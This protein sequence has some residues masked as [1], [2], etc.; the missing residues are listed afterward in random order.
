MTEKKSLESSES[1]KKY[2]KYFL[3]FISLFSLLLL[4]SKH[5]EISESIRYALRFCV[6]SIIP[7]IFPF[8]IFADFLASLCYNGKL[9]HLV[10]YI[11]GVNLNCFPAIICGL[12]CGF[13]SGVK[14]AV[15]LYDEGL[16]SKK[17]LE[18]LIGIIN[19]PSFAFS[20][21][22]VGLGMLGSFYDGFVLYS[23][24]VISS[25]FL[26]QFFRCKQRKTMNTADFH[27]QNFDLSNSIKDAG[28]SS[29]VVTSYIVFFSIVIKL[30][31]IF[32]KD[33]EAF[34]LIVS[35]IEIGNATYLISQTDSLSIVFKALLIGFSLGFSGISVHLQAIAL[36]PGSISKAIYYK[37]KLLQG[38]ICAV[39]FALYKM[40]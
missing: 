8:F 18:N 28:F 40:I 31:S 30:L 36:L 5:T 37:T 35:F 2:K 9:A 32:I 15:K 7:S 11:F 27:G 34:A 17:E 4:I 3:F 25:V 12:I 33:Q 23:I 10:T 26:A 14:W 22:A 39:F 1:S 6:S 19:L 24:T 20:V 29:L 21:C 16:I 13:P 38:L